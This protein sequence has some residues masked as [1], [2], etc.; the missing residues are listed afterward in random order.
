M[1][2]LLIAK[3]NHLNNLILVGRKTF[4]ETYKGMGSSR[5]EGLELFYGERTF[6]E[7]RLIPVLK[8]SDGAESAIFVLAYFNDDIAGYAKIEF[9]QVP[10]CVPVR[11]SAHFAQAYILK[12][13]QKRGIG[14]KL[15][16]KI[17]EI[18]KNRSY[19]ALWLG[20][21]EENLAAINYHQKMGFEKVGTVDWK[22]FHEKI[23]YTDTDIVMWRKI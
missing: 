1:I 23:E 15:F 2:S 14:K 17:I 21:W 13:F 3:E 16:A 5:P 7:E 22:F 8:N 4:V 18:A 6:N 19:E 12:E 10:E 11:N 20:V 9:D